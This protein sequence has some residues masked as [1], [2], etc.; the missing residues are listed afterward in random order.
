MVYE[1]KPKVDAYLMSHFVRNNRQ[2]DEL[3]RKQIKQ[4][5]KQV[6]KYVVQATRLS[7]TLIKRNYTM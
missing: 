4:I 3:S 1:A 7:N 6:K 5:R 2:I